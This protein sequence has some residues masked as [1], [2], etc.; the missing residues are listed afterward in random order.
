MSKSCTSRPCEGDVRF[1]SPLSSN[2]H[3]LCCVWE[4]RQTP[5][6]SRTPEPYIL[7][8]DLSHSRTYM[9]IFFFQ[10]SL[11]C[12]SLSLTS[13][14]KEQRIEAKP[15]LG[16]DALTTKEANRWQVEKS[17]CAQEATITSQLSAGMR[18]AGLGGATWIRWKLGSVVNDEPV[19]ICIYIYISIDMYVWIRYMYGFDM[20]IIHIRIPPL[21]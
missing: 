12:S 8:A 19:Y 18:P 4:V 6:L 2:G 14:T 16:P 3:G 20:I 7:V 9:M 1:P 13:K 5:R 15:P 10:F 11:Q 21:Q 17:N